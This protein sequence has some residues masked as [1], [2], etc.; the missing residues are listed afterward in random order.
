MSSLFFILFFTAFTY[1]QT[2]K[3]EGY[4]FDSQYNEPLPGANIYLE[5]TSFGAAADLNGKYSIT[6][7][8]AG[9][10]QLVV[11]YIGYQEK[12]IDVT[13]T[14]GQS[15]EQILTLDFQTLEGEVIEVTAQAEGQMQAIN[16]QL[17]SNT[18]SNIVSEARIEEL[19]DVNAAESIGRLPG[20]AILRSGGEANKI[21]IRG[22]SPKFNTVT[23]NGVRMPATDQNDRSVD[24]SLISSNMLDGIEVKKAITADMEAD[25]TAGSVDLRLK[26]APEGLR[27]ELFG[28]GG[29]AALTDY[30]GNYKL[31]GSISNRFLQNK[32]GV[33]L[34]INIDEFDRSADK[35]NPDYEDFTPQGDTVLNIRVTN[36]ELNEETILRGRT[37]GSFVMDYQ[38]PGNGKIVA[39]SFY[40]KL[41]SN[42]LIRVNRTEPTR[43]RL[44]MFR[45]EGTTSILT[46]GIGIEQ[47]FDWMN[48]TYNIAFT[49]SQT[50]NPHDYQWGFTR[51]E[52]Q[53]P[54]PIDQF[55]HPNQ[56]QGW[57][58]EKDTTVGFNNPM[59][60]DRIWINSIKRTEDLITTDINLTFPFIF[61]DMSGYI[62]VGTKFKYLERINDQEQHGR[63][64]LQYA[65][66]GDANNG[67]PDTLNVFGAISLELSDEWDIANIFR[68]ENQGGLGYNG[69]PIEYERI[70]DDHDRG[71]FLEGDYELGSTFRES[72]MMELT[73]ALQRSQRYYG[74]HYARNAVGSEG[75]DYKGKEEYTAAYLMTEI[76]VLNN[77]IVMPGIRYENE[78]TKYQGQRFRE[79]IS[80]WQDQAPLQYEDLKIERDNEFWLPMFHLNYDAISWLKLRFAY[81]N[82]LL[83]PDY[84]QYA[85]ITRINTERTFGNAANST[86]KPAK[87]QN[88]DYSMSVYDNYVGFFTFSYFTKEISDYI[89]GVNLTLHPDIPL[90]PGLNIPEDWVSTQPS[91]YTYINNPFKANYDGIELDWQTHFWY[92][93][94]GLNGLIFNANY[95][96]ID[97]E[98]KYKTFSNVEGDSTVPIFPNRPFPVR[99]IWE[100]EEGSRKGRMIDQPRH[101]LNLTLGY[102]YEGFSARLSYLF[103][104]DRTS[105]IDGTFPDLDS[106]TDDFSRFDLSLK[107]SLPYNIDL[108]AN[109]S[110]INSEPDRRFR[111]SN[112]STHRPDFIEYYGF[113]FDVGLRYRL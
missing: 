109:F 94:Y 57:Q 27:F 15:F 85:P 12:R 46:G 99:A 16:Q 95:T 62:K 47:D 55:T 59:E 26:D 20:V 111:T 63:A 21:A 89:Y 33:I 76:K 86:I 90:L 29:Y 30:S 105:G 100:L 68:N 113:T 49:S 4:V 65:G 53:Y 7:I 72:S 36:L 1:A 6:G 84:I 79:S 34:N 61:A 54:R 67:I 17:A 23:V 70:A 88:F 42:A 102:D 69:I 2:G 77:L 106:F 51:E 43:Q 110:N 8:P 92:L 11:R 31:N 66:Y 28:Q 13:I 103:Q 9:D 80:A 32:L 22:L 93:P 101:I 44:D 48:Y 3:I 91:M 56:L 81:T 19:P 98:T 82:T 18:I 14:A 5:G 78:H 41:N 45:R 25:A 40:N 104:A 97:S 64:G 108:I 71:N 35:L 24:L 74:G 73:R 87:S 112:K 38:L 58:I 60:L 83:K 50:D 52:G 75:S 107:Q 37:G 10:Y 39:N 96:Y